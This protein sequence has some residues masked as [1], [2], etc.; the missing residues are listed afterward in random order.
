MAFSKGWLPNYLRLG[1]HHLLSLPLAE[2]IRVQLG[3]DT[4]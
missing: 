4:Y 1:P 2:F 3:A